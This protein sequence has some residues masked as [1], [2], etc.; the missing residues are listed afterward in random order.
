ME[1]LPNWIAIQSQYSD[2][3]EY[4]RN[5][6]ISTVADAAPNICSK[7]SLTASNIF[8]ILELALKLKCSN[9]MIVKAS[10]PLA[11]IAS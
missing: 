6:T 5:K 10:F 11:K 2:P 3:T 4:D 7:K 9:F 8:V 1:K